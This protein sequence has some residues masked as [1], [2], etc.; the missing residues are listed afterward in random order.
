MVSQAAGVA[1]ALL[2]LEAAAR[3]QRM[4][5]GCGAWNEKMHAASKGRPQS[6]AYIPCCAPQPPRASPLLQLLHL[7]VHIL[8]HL[9]PHLQGAGKQSDAA[10]NWRPQATTCASILVCRPARHPATADKVDRSLM[11]L[12]GQAST[13]AAGAASLPSMVLHRSHPVGLLPPQVKTCVID[14]GM[15]TT[16]PDLPTRAPLPDLPDVLRF[17]IC[18]RQSVPGCCVVLLRIGV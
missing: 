10:E 16:H 9:P 5:G 14:S 18:L 12:S 1:Y 13:A 15:A 7:A 17:L 6:R 11:W 4:A 8:L 3:Q 2:G